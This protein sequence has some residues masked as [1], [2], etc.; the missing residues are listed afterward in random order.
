[1]SVDPESPSIA[2]R[3]EDAP[4][5]GLHLAKSAFIARIRIQ[6][7]EVD[8]APVVLDTVAVGNIVARNVPA[9]VVRMGALR[10]NILG[11]GFLS[12]LSARTLE[13][14]RLVLKGR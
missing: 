13:N 9:M 11:Q 5:L 4:R 2:L 3:A 14:N 12:R 1:M 10:E 7:G 6:T 8:A